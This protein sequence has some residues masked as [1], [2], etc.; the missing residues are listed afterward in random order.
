MINPN[1]FI[2]FLK[3]KDITSFYGVPDSALKGFCQAIEGEENNIIT[4]NEGQA[5]ALSLGESLAKGTLSLIY[6][7]NSGLGNTVN[8]VLSL[9]H[10]KVYNL[11]LFFMIGQ[12]GVYAKDEPQHNAMGPLTQEMCEMMGFQTHSLEKKHSLED[13][14]EIVNS[15]LLGF[16]ENNLQA[17]LVEPGVF[18]EV[19]EEF[20][21]TERKEAIKKIVKEVTSS[22][23]DVCFISTTGMISRELNEVLN[24]ENLDLPFFPCVGGM[25]YASS[26]AASLSR[27]Q[28]NK[29]VVLLDGD[30][31][32][33]MHMG[34]LSSFKRITDHNFLHIL[35]D[36]ASHESVGGMSTQC[37]SEFF[38]PLASLMGYKNSKNYE[39]G[40]SLL[41]GLSEGNSF[42]RFPI[43]KG[44]PKEL[45]RPKDISLLLK[46]FQEKMK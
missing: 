36:N 31:A 44:H 10:S 2:S 18:S 13:A 25:G 43:K 41:K 24:E 42:F 45:S 27:H 38:V 34:A 17:L 1:D 16:K 9:A 6:L 14:K 19:G 39:E 15:L 37:E 23:L 29:L 12:R 21:S 3:E 5:V 11:P 28:K 7:Q 33:L 40:D 35:L 30:G 26:I 46:S 20:I 32:A 8:P 4:V 22:S